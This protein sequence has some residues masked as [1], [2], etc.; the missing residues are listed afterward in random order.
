[1]YYNVLFFPDAELLLFGPIDALDAIPFY[2]IIFHLFRAYLIP[3]LEHP[4]YPRTVC[5]A[6]DSSMPRPSIA[7]HSG[8]VCPSITRKLFCTHARCYPKL[9]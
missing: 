5:L 8:A 1:M 3:V 4:E 9:S 2:R 6:Q 7:F